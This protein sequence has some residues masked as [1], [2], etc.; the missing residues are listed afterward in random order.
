MYNTTPHQAY[1]TAALKFP[2]RITRSCVKIPGAVGRS[3]VAADLSFLVVPPIPSIVVVQL[4]AFRAACISHV[5][6]TIARALRDGNAPSWFDPDVTYRAACCL[7]RASSWPYPP[8]RRL[9]MRHRCSQVEVDAKPS[10]ARGFA[11]SWHAHLPSLLV[12]G[13]L[14]RRSGPRDGGRPSW[15]KVWVGVGQPAETSS[16]TKMV[17][18]AWLVERWEQT[19]FERSWS[20]R[21]QPC[22][23]SRDR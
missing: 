9:G 23:S 15:N 21:C 19:L 3:P 14:P 4:S 8:I 1:S 22:P 12:L 10:R 6:G 18:A 5:N 20:A 16:G 17:A 11:P 2:L 7:S 13:P